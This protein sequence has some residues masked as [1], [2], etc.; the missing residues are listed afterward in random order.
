MFGNPVEIVI[1]VGAA[2][3]LFGGNK[4]RDVARGL[5]AAQREFKVGQVEADAEAERLRQAAQAHPA[6]P[7]SPTEPGKTTSTDKS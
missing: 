3:L 4:I 1:I 5:G 2:V 7:P 6:T